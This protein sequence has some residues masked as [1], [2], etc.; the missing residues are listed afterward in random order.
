MPSVWSAMKE[1][2]GQPCSA[3]RHE[4]EVL[5]HETAAA[6]QIG[7]ALRPSG[8]DPGKLPA[9][10][11]DLIAA[12]RQVLF[13]GKQIA[14]RLKPSTSALIGWPV[15]PR[16]IGPAIAARPAARSGDRHA[17]RRGHAVARAGSS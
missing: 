15:R 11:S 16:P 10:L 8:T 17:P 9:Q 14:S 1:Q 12:P 6:E 2:L 13:G 5:H 4:H 3:G 7:K